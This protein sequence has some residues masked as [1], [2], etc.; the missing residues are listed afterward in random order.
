MALTQI[1]AAKCFGGQQLVCEHDSDACGVTMRFGL[2]LPPQ[3]EH[4]P[5]PAITWLSGLT[6]TEQ[7]FITKAGAQRAAAELGVILVAPDTSPRGPNV[8]DAPDGAYDLG[9]GAGFYVNA[10]A[11]PYAAH[12]HMER[13]VAEE[14]PMV[15]AAHFPLDRRRHGLSGHS[16][17]G[18]GALTLHLKYPDIFRSVS[19]F[20]PIVAPAQVPWGQ[21]A[22]SAYL[23]RDPE[24]WAD[25]DATALVTR[26]PTDAAILIDQGS[27][28][29]FLTEQLRPDLFAAACEAAGQSLTLRHQPGYDHSYYFVASFID[30]HLRHHLAAWQ[31]R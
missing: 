9:L 23:G 19:A 1:A 2:Y 15:L 25:H 16:M 21:K 7:N 30:D 3:A 17:G 10:T 26:Q 13:Y 5:C 18:H 12:Y 27:D 29:P 4:G 24:V 6:C 31:R 28:D 14:L 8:A 20:A 22:F 11:Q